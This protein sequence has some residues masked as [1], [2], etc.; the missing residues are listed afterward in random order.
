M[1]R[2]RLIALLGI[3][4]GALAAGAARAQPRKHRIGFLGGADANPGAQRSAIDPF[5]QS[6]RELGHVEGRNLE[7]HY[8]WAEGRAERL[9]GLVQ[10]LLALQPS[11]IV[12]FGPGPALATKKVTT[13]MPILAVAVDNPVEMGLAATFARPGGNITGIS[14]FS[15]ELVAKRLELLKELVPTVRRAA[16][17]MNP[18][19]IVSRASF[20]RLLAGF[21][22]A[23][24][25]S[26]V[27]VDASGPEQFDAV[28]DALARDR[29]DGVLALA[30]SLFWTHRARLHALVAKHRLP[31]VWGQRDYLE[32]GGLA[33]Y[34]SDFPT[35][36]RRAAAM[37]DRLLKGA[38]PA[39]TPFEQA[40]KLD[41]A[42][43]LKAAQALGIAVP[44]S[45]LIV[46][47]HVI[48]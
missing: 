8:R 41:L 17:L 15:G 36:F 38:T 10:E 3:A 20:E 34:Q 14:S 18:A 40:T 37:A 25:L 6:L 44:P 26:I 46:A 35:M 29:V 1:D 39:D 42:I 7:I 11:L 13:T 2:R 48:Q 22:R 43:N 33:S 45:L 12:A 32:G 24:D 23:L 47:D 19:T 27:L 4:T 5:R 16:V 31:S 21:E 28:F 30:D 9:P